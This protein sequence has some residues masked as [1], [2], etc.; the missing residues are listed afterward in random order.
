MSIHHGHLCGK[1]KRN[2]EHHPDTLRNAPTRKAEL[3][4]ALIW[5]APT[6]LDRP[7]GQDS[8]GPDKTRPEPYPSYTLPLRGGVPPPFPLLREGGPLLREGAPSSLLSLK[9]E[10]K[11]ALLRMLSLSL[12]GRK[13]KASG[14]EPLHRRQLT[15]KRS[16]SSSATL[17]KK[18]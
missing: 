3:C 9:R 7:T 18:G 4:S 14:G 2:D 6:C 16:I 1:R 15:M 11:R 10:G 13:E 12:R 17:R 8:T 5:M